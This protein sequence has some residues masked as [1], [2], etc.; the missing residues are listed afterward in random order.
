MWFSFHR[1]RE[2]RNPGDRDEPIIFVEATIG[3][4]NTEVAKRVEFELG[5]PELA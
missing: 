4:R 3:L 5:S 2:G 1:D